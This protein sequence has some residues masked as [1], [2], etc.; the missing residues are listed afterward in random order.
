MLLPSLPCILILTSCLHG[1][2]SLDNWKM[3]KMKTEFRSKIREEAKSK[4]GLCEA[5]ET[6]LHETVIR[7]FALLITTSSDDQKD[8]PKLF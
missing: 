3:L 4:S 1:P 2:I 6:K 7:L 8:G 5:G